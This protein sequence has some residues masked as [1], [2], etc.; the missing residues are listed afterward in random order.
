MSTVTNDIGIELRSK[1]IGLECWYAN[2][3]GKHAGS[4]FS[5]AFG[6]KVA[7]DIPLANTAHPEEYRKYEG[8]ANIVVWCTW[9][10]DGRDAPLTSSD[11]T[12]DGIQKGLQSLI[13]SHIVDMIVERPCWDLKLLF[14]PFHRIQLLCDHVPGDPS[15][16]GNWEL[17]F[18]GESY[19]FGPGKAMEIE[20]R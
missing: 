17:H 1:L 19:Y 7:R 20:N 4:T 5:L 15:F 9:R 18:R 12:D 16:D 10:L 13:G 11:D 2:A 3:G 14:S 6:E 8:E